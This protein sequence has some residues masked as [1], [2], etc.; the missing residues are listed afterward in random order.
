MR[1]FPRHE[2][3]D[4]AVEAFCRGDYARVRAEAAKVERATVDGDVKLAARTLVERTKPDRLAVGLRGLAGLLLVLLSAWWI[5][6]GA[7]PP[8]RSP[9]VEHVH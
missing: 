7:P 3:L 6:H 5:V 4:A 8:P 9:P 2:G 1:D